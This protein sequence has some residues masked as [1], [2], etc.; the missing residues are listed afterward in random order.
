MGLLVNVCCGWTLMLMIVGVNTQT[1][2]ML[3]KILN[4]GELKNMMGIHGWE[5]A[6]KKEEINIGHLECTNIIMNLAT[7]LKISTDC[8]VLVTAYTAPTIVKGQ[9]V[10]MYLKYFNINSFYHTIFVIFVEIVRLFI[11]NI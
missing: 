9:I 10:S 3:A 11:S 7:T 5:S 2:S 8:S 4:N 1:I 6:N